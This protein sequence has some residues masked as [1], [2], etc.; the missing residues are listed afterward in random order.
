MNQQ[1][2]IRLSSVMLAVALV[3]CSDSL[4]PYN[5]DTHLLVNMSALGLDPGETFQ[6]E[7]TAGGQPAAAEW[8]SSNTAIATVSSAGVVTA[9]ASGTAAI[10]A[11]STA[12]PS[13]RV[14][15][16]VTVFVLQGTELTSGVPLPIS[17]SGARGSTQIYRI[18]VPP[19]TSLLRVQT[20]GGSGDLDIYVSRQSPTTSTTLAAC[21]GFNAGNAELCNINNPQSGTWY[22][23]VEVWDAYDGATLTATL[24]P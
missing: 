13:Q 4:D 3:G 7:A 8:S 10:T 17:S 1:L 19:G 18:F 22:I 12:D 2:V 24:N 14:T 15:T 9:I 23:T 11:T 20:G 5:A 6:L 21:F 16:S